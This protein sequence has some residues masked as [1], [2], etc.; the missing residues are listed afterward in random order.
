MDKELEGKNVKLKSKDGKIFEVPDTILR[1]SKLLKDITIDKEDEVFT[2]NE[3][4][5]DCLKKVIEYLNHYKDFE[6]KEIPKP[7][8]D[9]P[10]EKFFKSILNDEWTFNYLNNLSIEEAVNIINAA[11]YLQIDGLLNLLSAKL[12]YELCN[13][14]PDELKQKFQIEDDLTPEEIAELNKYPLG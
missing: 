9:N 11:N 14:S 10:D 8:P 12:G 13:G 5:G 6:P 4:N 3:V 7:F 1:K 2:I